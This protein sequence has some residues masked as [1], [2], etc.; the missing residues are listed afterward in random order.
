MSDCYEANSDFLIIDLLRGLAPR[1]THADSL[2]FEYEGTL[3]LSWPN[4]TLLRLLSL[5]R[6]IKRL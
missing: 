2:R 5:L 3:W 4:P 6:K 1:D